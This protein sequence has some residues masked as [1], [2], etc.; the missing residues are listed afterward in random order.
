[1]KTPLLA[2]LGLTALAAV[3]A[4]A[5][6]RQ[7][8][9]GAGVYGCPTAAPVAQMMAWRSLQLSKGPTISAADQEEARGFLYVR[10]QPIAAGT[11][12]TYVEAGP[13]RAIKVT[14]DGRTF[15]VAPGEVR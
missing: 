10:C 4:L 6:E 8:E 13:D 7:G 14:H 12:V 11:R 5:Q 15:W 3:P 1:M 9:I 2:A